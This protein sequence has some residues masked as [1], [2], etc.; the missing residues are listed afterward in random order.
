[1]GLQRQRGFYPWGIC[2]AA[3]VPPEYL[4][5]MSNVL[6]FVFWKGLLVLWS[7]VGRF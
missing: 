6:R 1:M 2:Y 3:L 4:K 5:Q 7:L